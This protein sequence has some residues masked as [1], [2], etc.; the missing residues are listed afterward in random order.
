MQEV[1]VAEALCK[2]YS[3]SGS[4]IR[5]LED[6][7]FKVSESEFI[8]LEGPSGAGKTTLLNIVG[9]IDKP[10]SG[11]IVVFDQDLSNCDED[12]L[13]TFRCI[14][15]GFVFQ[16]YN[17]ISTLTARENIE[18][19]SELAGWTSEKAAKRAEELLEMVEMSHRAEHFPAQLSGGE[20]QRVA[21]ARALANDPPLMLVDEPTGNLDEKT[22]EKITRILKELQS[23]GKT[24]LVATHDERIVTLADRKLFL[25]EG[26]LYER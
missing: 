25:N 11:R 10:T 19:P 12:F 6:L 3:L 2:E 17:L 23:G 24:V 16:S 5:V 13:A 8:V 26:G 7:T 1:I 4:P 18:F 21:F 9:G 22:G 14:N 20:M 15:V